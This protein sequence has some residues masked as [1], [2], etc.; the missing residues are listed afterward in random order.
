MRDGLS[1][2]RRAAY[3]EFGKRWYRW[4]V[5]GP[6]VLRGVV[7]VLA[8]VCAV[9]AGRWLVVS[10]DPLDVPWPSSGTWAGVGLL[11]GVG[12]AVWSLRAMFERS[13]R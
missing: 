13:Y 3:A 4:F 1:V 7:G 5:Y 6:L 9:V 11:A 8:V 12:V 2:A 10:A